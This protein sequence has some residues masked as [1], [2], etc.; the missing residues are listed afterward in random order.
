VLEFVLPLLASFLVLAVTVGFFRSL[1]APRTQRQDQVTDNLLIRGEHWSSSQWSI[2][3]T[4]YEEARAA[5]HVGKI[6]FA[7][8]G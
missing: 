6:Q 4:D 2:L 7:S 3:K 5:E 8:D 1:R